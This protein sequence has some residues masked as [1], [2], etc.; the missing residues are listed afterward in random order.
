MSDIIF[1]WDK[2][3]DTANKKKHGTSFTEAQ[4]V[5]ADENGYC[6]MTPITRKTKNDLSFSGSILAFISSSSAT[7]TGRTRAS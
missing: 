2:K 3:K 5:F 4:T 7:L 6:F 1:E